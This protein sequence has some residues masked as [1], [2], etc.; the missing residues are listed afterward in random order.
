MAIDQPPVVEQVI[1]HAA[2]L[3]PIAGDAAFSVI[4]LPQR[5]LETN[6]R[7]DQALAQTPGLSLFRRTSSL[8]ANPTTQGV[9]LRG[10]AGSGASRAL[11]T[12]DGV[13]QNDP[14]GGWVIWSGI[15]SEGVESARVV[16]GA[17]AGPYGAGALTGTIALDER[18][19][20]GFEAN[21]TLGELDYKRAAVV[22][23]VDYGRLNFF[24]SATGE[25]SD[26]WIP[27]RDRRG[28]ADVPL[29][30]D[31]WSAAG[32]ISADLGNGAVAAVRIS[33]FQERRT[34][35]LVGA[36]SVAR[37]SSV[38]LTLAKPDVG[39]ALGWRLQFWGRNSNLANTSVAV[40]AGRV[41][42]TPANNQ[43]D[44][45]ASGIGINAAIRGVASGVRWELGTDIRANEGAVNEFFR[46]QA[47][48]F[49]RVRD[50]GGRTM[51]GGVYVEASKQTGDTLLTA[52]VRVDRW[53]TY[54]AKRIERDTLSPVRAFTLNAPP[55]DRDGTVP[56]GRVG[57]KTALSPNLAVR[58]GAYAGFRPATLN[59]LHRP[60]RVG[61][62]VTEA[63]AALKPERL[64]GA[65]IGL[66]GQGMGGRFGITGFYNQ[67]ND[68]IANVT[69]GGPG[70]YPVAGV[71]PVGGVLRQRQNAGNVNAYGVE[72][73]ASRNW[74]E[75]FELSAA[76]AYTHAKVDGGSA[77]PQLTGLRPAQTPR[78]T[79]TA[80]ANW[81][82]IALVTLYG[83][84]RYESGR[85]DDDQNLRVL[86]AGTVF[87]ARVSY[88]VTPQVSVF[89]AAD[90]LFNTRL[91]TGRTADGV[92]SA[93]A[94]RVARVGISLKL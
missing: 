36:Y 81:R 92:I 50:A 83:A 70:T 8:A 90:N 38:S 4:G 9:S 53:R 21:A 39:D 85:F 5:V 31:D 16:R 13:P 64:Y 35:G 42:T 84:V 65:E 51:V 6:E 14:F 32:R 75:R 82:P 11:V 93:G 40:A 1:V 24:A 18:S 22:G 46:Y 71:I 59:E 61:N 77:A 17:G 52:G 67:L 28:A 57:I 56:T 54:H 91:Q 26:G 73:D 45:P 58:G 37:G 88:A 25:R 7:L 48:N 72:A 41:G 69:V 62:D 23:S 10:I 44:T 86:K 43:F 20:P 30:L 3:S 63:N 76:L 12:L 27:V 33:T 29:T 55:P 68:A 34:A 94:P 47:P 79:A 60:F 2:R 74:G 87:D 89:A 80:S 66:D 49:T 19:T 15:A 78:F